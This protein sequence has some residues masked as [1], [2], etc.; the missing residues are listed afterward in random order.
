MQIKNYGLK[1]DIPDSR[2]YIFGAT[3]PFTEV[4]S[5]G[6]WEAYLPERE[7]QNLFGVDPQACVSYTVLNCVETLIKKKYG[8]EKN[9]SERFLASISGTKEGGNSPRTVCNYLRKCG[10]VPQE[11]WPF[12]SSV[13]TFEKYY[14]DIPQDIKNLALEFVNEWDFKYEIV[15]STPQMITMALKCSPLLISVSAWFEKDGK[16]YRP[17]GMT[18]NHATT[19]FY[20]REG[21]FR[22]V[23]DSYDKPCIKDVE[24]NAIPMQVVRFSIEK[25]EKTVKKNWIID[26]WERLVDLI[27]DICAR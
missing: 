10:V 1:L 15:P 18:D 26:L 27:K 17:E 3:L 6:N 19:M 13:D 24:W 7:F 12:D 4:Q 2:D 5:D 23:F 8:I 22:R 16:F 20:E 11:V 21:E 25:R 14:E 9:F